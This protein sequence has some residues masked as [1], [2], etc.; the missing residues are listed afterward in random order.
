MSSMLSSPLAE[1][2][3]YESIDTAVEIQK[4]HS[5]ADEQWLAKLGG[6]FYPNVLSQYCSLVNGIES[7]G[8]LSS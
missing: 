8:W 7:R 5:R 1:K 4:K 2:V 6:V 3:G